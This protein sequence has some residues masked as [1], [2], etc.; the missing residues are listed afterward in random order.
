MSDCVKCGTRL[1]PSGRGR[2]PSYCSVACRRSAENELRRVTN[3]LIATETDV[4]K[5]DALIAA[6]YVA[7]GPE[8]ERERD[9]LRDVEIPRLEE[10]LR[11][12]LAASDA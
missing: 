11:V 1:A 8:A 10:R 5:L 2:P 7:A 3:H 6:R 9:H 4:R 12:L